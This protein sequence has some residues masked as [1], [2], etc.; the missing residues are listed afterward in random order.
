MERLKIALLGP[1]YPPYRGAIETH[2]QEVAR[3]LSKNHDV[4]VITTALKGDKEFEM[5]GDVRVVRV[6]TLIEQDVPQFS[7]PPLITIP[8]F[9]KKALEEYEKEK[10]DVVILHSRWYHEIMTAANKL[11]EKGAKLV[12]VAHEPFKITIDPGM[13]AFL[14]SYDKLIE[15]T[16]LFQPDGL[17]A[18]SD[19]VKESAVNE[20]LMGEEKCFTVYNGID[21][22]FYRP[23]GEEKIS[24]RVC[25]LSRIIVQKGIKYLVR[26]AKNLSDIEDFHIVIG[27][28]GAEKD[29]LSRYAKSKKLPVEFVGFVKTS[30]V[31]S[32]YSKSMLYAL[33]SLWEAFG[34]VFCEAMSC[35]TCA[36]GASTG[37]IPEVLEAEQLVP[38]KD[39][40]ALASKIRHLLENENERKRLEKKGMDNVKKNFTWDKVAERTEN[41]LEKLL[42][43]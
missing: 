8:D 40:I 22:D 37:G 27:G 18:V 30:D 20:G 6:K 2:I 35:G 25:C 33:P 15:A 1:F 29:K 13:N 36:V 17:L 14:S 31:P 11:K 10:F 42:E 26:S 43:N 32:F 9:P 24:G 38:P 7:P 3:R 41:A 39:E 5:D 16:K 4:T 21:T 23:T 34:V 28:K 19:Y 12:F